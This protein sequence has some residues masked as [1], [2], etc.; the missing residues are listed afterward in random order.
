MTSKYK[1]AGFPVIIDSVYDYVQRLCSGFRFEGLDESER[2]IKTTQKEIDEQRQKLKM[3]NYPVDDMSDEQI[4]SLAVYVKFCHLI[5]ERDC[6][7]IQ[8]CAVSSYGIAYLFIPGYDTNKYPDKKPCHCRFSNSIEIVNEKNPIIRLKNNNI[9]VYS[10]P[11]CD[12]KIIK[13]AQYVPLSAICILTTD[14]T[15]RIEEISINSAYG[16]IL[17][18]CHSFLSPEYLSAPLNNLKRILSKVQIYTLGS[19]A[20]PSAAVVNF[21]GLKNKRRNFYWFTNF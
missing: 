15:D 7:I 10:S 18:Q 19:N 4:E 21:E 1:I 20:E 12:K 17:R 13:K 5:T 9:Y 2:Y 3:T 14:D 11:W 8:G 16:T 6:L